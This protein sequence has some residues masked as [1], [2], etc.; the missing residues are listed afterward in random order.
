MVI[1]S[2]QLFL[3]TGFHKNGMIHII[4]D[5]KVSKDIAKFSQERSVPCIWKAGKKN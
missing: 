5:N 2:S 1:I 3:L 4:R